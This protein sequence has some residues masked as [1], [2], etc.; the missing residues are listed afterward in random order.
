[1]SCLFLLVKANN[2]EVAEISLGSSLMRQMWITP[3]QLYSLVDKDASGLARPALNGSMLRKIE[4]SITDHFNAFKKA[5]HPQDKDATKSDMYYKYQQ[6]EDVQYKRCL[7]SSNS[8]TPCLTSSPAVYIHLAPIFHQAVINY[9]RECYLD[10][11]AEGLH[12]LNDLTKL[13]IWSSVHAN[14]SYHSAHHHQD[15]QISGILYITTP[16]DAGAVVFNDP[17]GQL[18]PFG[19]SVHIVPKPGQLILFP[20]W[21]VHS[22]LPTQGAQPRISVSFNYNGAWE[23][24]SDVNQAFYT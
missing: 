20:S 19:K 12:K 14:G 9:L 7:K 17:R 1:M 8:N 21:L 6:G 5:S 10:A 16:P 11:E 4:V 13:H 23:T 18:P 24:T 15:A 3:I 22:V 2:S